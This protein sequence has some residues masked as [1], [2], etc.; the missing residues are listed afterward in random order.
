MLGGPGRRLRAAT[1]MARRHAAPVLLL[2]TPPVRSG[3]PE[4]SIPG[5]E[6]TWFSPDPV[7]TRGEAEYFGS[8]ARARGWRSVIVVS[9]LQQATR[10][11]LR[12]KRCFSGTVRVVG[13]PLGALQTAYY[14]VYEWGALAKAVLWQRAC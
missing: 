9:S 1:E 6:V 3:S 11:R 5:V 7:S 4:L 14:V 13:V 2:S 8:L 12:V 10:A